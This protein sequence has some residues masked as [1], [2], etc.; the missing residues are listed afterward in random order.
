VDLV[1]DW[2]LD[3]VTNSEWEHAPESDTSRQK[4]EDN[5]KLTDTS[6]RQRSS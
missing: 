1:A 3:F 2:I 6:K 4:K 5:K